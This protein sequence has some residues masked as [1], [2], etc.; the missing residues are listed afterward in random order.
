MQDYDLNTPTGKQAF[1]R[2]ITELIRNEINSYVQQVL[3]ERNATNITTPTITD[4][5]PNTNAVYTANEIRDL[6]LERL[7]QATFRR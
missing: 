2:W 7:E 1:Q 5:N 3:Y 4:I 6:R